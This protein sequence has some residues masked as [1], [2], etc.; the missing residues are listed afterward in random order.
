[1]VAPGI[2]EAL[3]ATAIGLF[4]AIPAVIAYNRFSHRVNRFE[5]GCSALPIGSMAFEPRAGAIGDGDEPFGGRRRAT[6]PARAGPGGP[7]S[8]ST[9]PRWS[10]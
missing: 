10:T 1:V 8:R 5:R 7:M 2:S 6:R 9:L 3:F 4:A